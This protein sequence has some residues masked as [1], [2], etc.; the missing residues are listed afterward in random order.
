MNNKNGQTPLTLAL[1]DPGKSNI[2]T[3]SALL[4]RGADPNLT[5]LYGFN[6]LYW[7]IDK[8]NFGG[9]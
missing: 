5:D 4:E 3:V 2:E 8:N 7:A 1:T 6:A 9:N